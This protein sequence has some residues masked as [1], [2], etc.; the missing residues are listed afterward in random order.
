MLSISSR[1]ITPDTFKFTKTTTQNEP[2]FTRQLKTQRQ[3]SRH[4]KT[5][6]RSRVGR[7]EFTLPHWPMAAVKPPPAKIFGIDPTLEPTVTRI[8]KKVSEGEYFSSQPNPDGYFPAMIG[9]G[10][11]NTLKLGVGDEIVLISSGADGSIANDIFSITAIIGNT[12]S[13]D[14]LGVFLPISAARNF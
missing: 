12:T 6:Q 11:A 3:L 2:R 7:R 10:L 9:R 5:M 8:L 13:F 4:S 1:W 14:R